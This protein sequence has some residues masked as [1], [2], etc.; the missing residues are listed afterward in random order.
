M[1]RSAK[2]KGMRRAHTHTHTYT[3]THTHTMPSYKTQTHPAHILPETGWPFA[4][5][6]AG[7][8]KAQRPIHL[9]L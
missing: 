4:L 9:H 7:P 8:P 3:H 6:A 5:G 1:V 2:F